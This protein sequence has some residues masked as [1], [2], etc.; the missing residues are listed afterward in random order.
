MAVRAQMEEVD[1]QE[2]NFV[3]DTNIPK[4]TFSCCNKLFIYRFVMPVDMYSSTLKP[5]LHSNFVLPSHCNIMERKY[6]ITFG[7]FQ[8]DFES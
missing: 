5:P 7:S 4:T 3:T 6:S 8:L 1:L 2:F